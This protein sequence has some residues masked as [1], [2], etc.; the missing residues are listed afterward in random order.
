M[1][2]QDELIRSIINS[3]EKI[4]PLN[5]MQNDVNLLKEKSILMSGATQSTNGKSGFVPAPASTEWNKFLRGDGTWQT[6]V[7]EGVGDIAIT[8]IGTSNPVTFGSILFTMTSSVP[9]IRELNRTDLVRFTGDSSDSRMMYLSLGKT[10]S[11]DN[12]NSGLELCKGLYKFKLNPPV[13]SY[14]N[15]N[16]ALPQ[17]T[18]VSDIELA[19]THWV[20]NYAYVPN[21]T[22]SVNA[23][24]ANTLGGIV[25][26][27]HLGTLDAG[28]NGHGTGFQLNCQ[29]NVYGDNRFVLQVAGR[30]HEV[31]VDYARL[32]NYANYDRW[33]R[34]IDGTY[35]VTDSDA[36]FASITIRN[37]SNGA[38]STIYNDVYSNI[39]S[40]CAMRSTANISDNAGYWYRNISAGTGSTPASSGVP[41]GSIYLQYS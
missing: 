7:T 33:G 23:T 39:T 16:V 22:N 9:I 8:D 24:N 4:P 1:A 6:V 3:L 12:V 19:S 13:N 18:G 41:Y 26:A 21:A 36:R 37:S 17:Y 25:D 34:L 32:A 40:S 29:H 31:A 15:M 2:T 5:I 20:N 14:I 11:G 38:T 27:Y 10:G 28:G 35:A 30:T